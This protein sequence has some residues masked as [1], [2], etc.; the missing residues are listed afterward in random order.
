MKILYAFLLLLACALPLPASAD[1]CFGA[2][3]DQCGALS[4]QGFRLA[5]CVANPILPQR[6]FCNVSAGSWTH[7]QC[8]FANRS[9]N[10]CAGATTALASTCRAEMV[11][12]ISRAARGYQWV[13][14]VDNQTAD[15]DGVVN[16]GAYC[17]S[18]GQT[19]H[20]DDIR[21]CCNSQPAPRRVSFPFNAGRPSLWVCR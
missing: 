12:A 10:F 9:G 5:A 4:G 11:V 19:V 21:Y 7:D 18:A 14:L 6:S 16:R 3:G 2:A 1:R 15:A 8:C 17:A 13:R 20:R